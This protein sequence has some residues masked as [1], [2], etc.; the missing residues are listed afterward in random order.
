MRCRS[1]HDV[2]TKV[3]DPAAPLQER[4]GRGWQT[5]QRMDPVRRTE[6]SRPPLRGLCFA[7]NVQ[8]DAGI[9][10]EG[11]CEFHRVSDDATTGSTCGDVEAISSQRSWDPAAG[12]VS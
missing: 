8:F 9:P 2:E 10:V 4:Q 6:F 1:P 7:E 12:A 11:A 3:G 5:R